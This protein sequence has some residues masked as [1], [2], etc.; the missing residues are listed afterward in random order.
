MKKYSKSSGFYATVKGNFFSDN[1]QQLE[2][3]LKK[4]K[5]YI[6]QPIR[7]NCKLCGQ[8]LSSQHDFSKHGVQYVFCRACDH[9]N[10]LYED[11]IEFAKSIYTDD[12]GA[13]YSKFYL[14]DKYKD[15]LKNIYVPKAEFLIEHLGDKISTVYD[16]GCGLGH[17]VNAFISM[18]IDARGGDVSAS[19]V[20][21]GNEAIENDH[22]V[23]P[24]DSLAIESF[25]E[26]ISEIKVDVLSAMAVIEH[27]SNLDEFIEAV[28]NCSFEYFYYSVPT[29]GLSVS[30]EAV[31][32]N[33]FPRHLSGG[34]THLFTEK[35]LETLHER[36]GVTPIAEWRFGT[37]VQ[38]IKR[39]IEVSLR[40]SNASDYFVNRFQNEFSVYSDKVQ[41]IIDK[42][43][44][45][46]QIHVICKKNKL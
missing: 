13:N 8:E 9:L 22:G 16:F 26:H 33:V 12:G 21:H 1:D 39:S 5:A 40:Q 17:L 46:S 23:R 31:F 44:N 18:G 38:D 6:A 4:N 45:C 42:S 37:D 14:D 7:F 36:L 15:R 41:A 43:H 19:L 34:H 28:K 11:T 3:A 20:D 35:S 30:I 24:L 10:G 25:G 32:D 29:Y 27:I 2:S